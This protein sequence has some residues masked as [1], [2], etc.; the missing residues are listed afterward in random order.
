MTYNQWYLI[1]SETEFMYWL[2]QTQMNI[3]DE[4]TSGMAEISVLKAS[5]KQY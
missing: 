4:V 1:F 3:S 2:I 5:P